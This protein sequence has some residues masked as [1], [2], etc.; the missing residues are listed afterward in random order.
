MKGFFQVLSRFPEG[1]G[2]IK[3]MR[4]HFFNRQ[5]PPIEYK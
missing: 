3:F 5:A 4:D 2:Q 1:W